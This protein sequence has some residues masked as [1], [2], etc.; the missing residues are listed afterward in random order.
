MY[1]K[2]RQAGFGDE[3]KK[4]ILTGT[5]V[6]SAGYYDAYYKKALKLRNLIYQDFVSAYKDV[7]LY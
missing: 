3:V 5:Y 4:R 1:E 2:T 6:L 7:I